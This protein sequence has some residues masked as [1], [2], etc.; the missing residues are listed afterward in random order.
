MGDSGSSLQQ[1][2]TPTRQDLFGS[3]TPRDTIEPWSCRKALVCTCRAT[4]TRQ[5]VIIGAQNRTSSGWIMKERWHK[6]LNHRARDVWMKYMCDLIITDAARFIL[7]TSARLRS[8]Y[9][10]LSS[11]LVRLIR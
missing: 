2:L 4:C 7:G 11:Y 1:R 6:I 8:A 3:P 5:C 9:C 10:G